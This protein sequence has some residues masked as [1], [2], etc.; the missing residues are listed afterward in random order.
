MSHVLC[1][2]W[3]PG[4][5]PGWHCALVTIHLIHKKVKMFSERGLLR[6]RGGGGGGG[7]GRGAAGRGVGGGAGGC[8]C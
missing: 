5:R 4:W 6:A 2:S 1:S 3:R 7:G 8:R